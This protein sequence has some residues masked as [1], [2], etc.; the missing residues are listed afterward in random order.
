[1]AN[2]ILAAGPQPLSA[3]TI[4]YV[5]PSGT[6]NI[7]PALVD[8]AGNLVV[9]GYGFTFKSTNA[10]IATVSSS[11]LV[12]GVRVGQTIVQVGYA[13]NAGLT[14]DVTVNVTNAALVVGGPLAQGDY[15]RAV[16]S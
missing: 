6:A 9:P 8:V 13:N 2:Q 14:C 15:D 4:L 7:Y 11:G 12:T 16:V 1:M 3:N 5:A 10:F